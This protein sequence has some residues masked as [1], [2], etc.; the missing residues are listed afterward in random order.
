MKSKGPDHPRSL[1]SLIQTFTIH[2]YTLT[3][4][5]VLQIKSK[6]PNYP[7]SICSLIWTSLFTFR[8]YHNRIFF[9]WRAKVLIIL[10]AYAIWSTPSLFTCRNYHNNILLIKSK[11][12]DHPISICSLIQTFT[13][14]LSN[15]PQLQFLQMTSRGPDYPTSIYSLD[16]HFSPAESTYIR[17]F[18]RGRAKVLIILQAY[19]V[20]SGPSLTPVHSTTSEGSLYEKQRPWPSNKHM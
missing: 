1:C 3:P 16:L 17:C 5:K 15:L 8:N 19:A 20:S 18:F 14:H 7:T 12:P 4:Q 9:R 2:L 10:Q 11:G 6:D 13:I